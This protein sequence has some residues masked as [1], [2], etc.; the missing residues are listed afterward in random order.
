MTHDGRYV[1]HEVDC[2]AQNG[3][4]QLE[5]EA[6]IGRNGGTRAGDTAS[7][8]LAEARVVMV[9]AA[10]RRTNRGSDFANKIDRH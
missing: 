7:R 9:V 3:A 2:A 8:T 4:A 1:A 5:N 10:R 6:R